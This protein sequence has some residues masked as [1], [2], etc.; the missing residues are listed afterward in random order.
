[1]RDP[2][3]PRDPHQ[4]QDLH[5]PHAHGPSRLWL[6]P[7]GMHPARLAPPAS[8]SDEQRALVLA[9]VLG[10]SLSTTAQGDEAP[11]D[12]RA[13]LAGLAAL[14]RMRGVGGTGV[15]AA[16]REAQGTTG[17][18]AA[19]IDCGDGGAPLRLLLTQASIAPGKTRLRGSRRLGERPHGP[20]LAA[21]RATLGP[22]GLSIAEGSPW[23]IE[24][25]GPSGPAPTAR[26]VIDGSLSSQYASSLLLGAA[27]LS[28]RE[29][30]PW[31]VTV[32]GQPSSRGY[33]AMTAR[34]LEAAG[35]ALERDGDTTTISSWKDVGPLPPVAGDWSSLGYLLLI[36]WRTGG[37][38]L[39]VDLGAA[40]PDRALLAIAATVGLRLER[41][42][43]A[44]DGN[45][46]P[47]EVA[48]RGE[49]TGGLEASGASCPDLLPTLAALACTLPGPST[50]RGVGVLRHKESDRLAGIEALVAAA[51]GACS[52]TP[53]SSGAAQDLDEDLLIE[54]PRSVRDPLVIESAGDHRRAM[55]AATLAVLAG[56][57]LELEGPGC[58]EKS[59]PGFWRE[60]ERAGALIRWG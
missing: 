50:L 41:V 52:R 58:V 32:T 10:R 13:L 31:A 34:W 57:S 3:E 59:F 40:H 53:S 19:E 24:I 45:Q 9:H 23:P 6:D 27:A 36:S 42:A 46:G 33:L 30:R 21:L 18:D 48:L 28:L 16:T 4:P 8:K 47:E 7:R 38:A 37:T 35:F 15:P 20:L 5:Q 39:G 55:A 60:L 22:A 51:G 17:A 1:M 54:P 26:F 44:S 49:A 14:A 12:V 43:P 2:D 29:G 25:D 56:V 11:A